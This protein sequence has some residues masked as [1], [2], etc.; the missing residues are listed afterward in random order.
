MNPAKVR[1]EQVHKLTDLPN[2][3]PAMARDFARLGITS[4]AELIGRD[5]A[6]LYLTL[7]DRTGTRQDPCVL[8][9]FMSVT[10][11]MDGD[12]PRPWWHYTTE[13][14]RR[15]GLTKTRAGLAPVC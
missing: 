6:E 10:A 13:R 15:H 14:K 9:V 11:F 12:A 2:I 1:R 4:P 7:C 8:D 5:P 3:G